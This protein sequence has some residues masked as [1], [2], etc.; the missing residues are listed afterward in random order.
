M[1][2]LERWSSED[3]PDRSAKPVENKKTKHRFF[4]LFSLLARFTPL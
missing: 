3:E 1:R 4:L 2:R